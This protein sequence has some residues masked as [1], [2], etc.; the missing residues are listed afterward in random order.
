VIYELDPRSARLMNY[1]HGGCPAGRHYCRIGPS[2]DVT[3]CPYI[4]L[5]AGNL[6][7]QGFG[8]IWR[9]AA[10]FQDFR[11]PAL[12]GRCGTCEFREI[13]GGCRCRAY[14]AT[15]DYLAE[16]PACSYQPG[17][18]GG[19]LITLPEEQTFGLEVAFELSWEEAA[20]ARL[21]M[22]PSFARGMVVKAVEAFARA[23]GSNQVTPELLREAKERWEGEGRS[24]FATGS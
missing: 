3:P 1:A 8:E 4:P 19:N 6:Q 14:A 10:L 24:P 20:K 11:S 17:R 7:D 16:D 9:M 2:G 15:G 22:I 13:C 12:G 21:T 18:Y 5:S 23:K